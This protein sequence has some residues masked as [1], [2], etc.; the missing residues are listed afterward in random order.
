MTQFRFDTFTQAYRET[1]SAKLD[2]QAVLR[3]IRSTLGGRAERRASRRWKAW[4]CGMGL[5]TALGATLAYASPLAQTL[6]QWVNESPESSSTTSVDTPLNTTP[7][8]SE[9]PPA[10]E[11]PPAVAPAP[12]T[13]SASALSSP[14]ATIAPFG[15]SSSNAALPAGGV[16]PRE[17]RAINHQARLRHSAPAVD[18]SS[19]YARAHRLQFDEHSYS[20]ALEAWDDYLA[21][22]DVG[23]R[24]DAR[25]NRAVCLVHL[26]HY[27]QARAE[28]T[29]L[30]SP[31]SA[32]AYRSRAS[33]LL[34]S[35]DALSR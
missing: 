30:A 33:T 19:L 24:S 29:R 4:L 10:A 11:T 18:A 34:Q 5:T 23:L 22:S 14:E 1:H 12:A 26:K 32:P 16:A 31:G 2:D 15:R 20:V 25:Y 21:T 7:L 35:L 9:R 27:E 6:L 13:A 28:L 8:P 17:T 3:R